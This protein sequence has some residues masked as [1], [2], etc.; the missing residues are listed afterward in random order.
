MKQILV[1]GIG[2]IFQG[3]DAFGCEI[4][5]QLKPGDFPA[6]VTVTDFGIRR[7]DLA[8]ALT[9]HYD[10][11]ILVDAASQGQPPGTLYL[12]KPD[13]NR[14]GATSRTA[15]DDQTLNPVSVIQMAQAIGK[16]TG[17]LFLIG[18][19]PAVL[20]SESGEIGLSGK[21]SRRRFRTR[22]KCSSLSS[23]IFWTGKGKHSPASSW[24]ER[25][26]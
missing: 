17:Q 11:V 16:V 1:A 12:I 25:K 19:E 20:E 18:C 15:V 24:R 3:D 13:V 26:S 10:A 8:Q 23:R 22:S 9:N 7:D 14:L 21:E 6:G 4:I 2:D 5:R